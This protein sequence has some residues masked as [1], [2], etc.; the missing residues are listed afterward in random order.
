MFDVGVRVM[1]RLHTMLGFGLYVFDV[2]VRL[3][4]G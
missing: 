1:V 4:Y 2:G 3:W